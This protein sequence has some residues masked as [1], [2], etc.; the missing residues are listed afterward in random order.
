MV[1]TGFSINGNG[2]KAHSVARVPFEKNGRL[3]NSNAFAQYFC[4]SP[5]IFALHLARASGF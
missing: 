1:F 2:A 5:R 3:G 4:R